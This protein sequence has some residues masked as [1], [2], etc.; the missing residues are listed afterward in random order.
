MTEQIVARAIT[1]H[2]ATLRALDERLEAPDASEQRDALKEEIIS[3][4]KLIEHEIG[5]LNALKDDV[6]KLVDKWKG[7]QA[8]QSLAPQFTEERP[9]VHADHIGAST[10]IE[11]G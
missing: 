5:D 1:E 11:K 6:K 7:L 9:V 10:F 8:D 2:R 4:F 3:F